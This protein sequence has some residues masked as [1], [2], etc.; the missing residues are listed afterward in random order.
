MLR[1]WDGSPYVEAIGRDLTVIP[2]PAAQE[3][4]KPSHKATKLAKRTGRIHQEDLEKVHTIASTA[5]EPP[6]TLFVNKESRF[7]TPLRYK[8]AF[9][10]AGSL[11]CISTLPSTLSSLHDRPQGLC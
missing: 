9:C 6:T 10:R 4:K 1:E 3:N 7:V 5:F 8:L 2:R 11:E